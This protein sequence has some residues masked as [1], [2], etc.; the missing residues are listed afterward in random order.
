MLALKFLWDL[1]TWYWPIKIRAFLV[2]VAILRDSF[3]QANDVPC[4]PQSILNVCTT[5]LW[6]V[7]RM[8]VSC[9]TLLTGLAEVLWWRAPPSPSHLTP[10][11]TVIKQPLHTVLTIRGA[12][13]VSTCIFHLQQQKTKIVLQGTYITYIVV[14]RYMLY[15]SKWQLCKWSADYSVVRYRHVHM[16]YY[17]HS[18]EVQDCHQRLSSAFDL[19]CHLI[20][21]LTPLPNNALL[22]NLEWVLLH[23]K[24]E[25]IDLHP[26]KTTSTPGFVLVTSHMYVT[27]LT[28]F[29]RKMWM[30]VTYANS[31]IVTYPL[32]DSAIP[33][34]TE[35]YDYWHFHSVIDY[36]DQLLW[37]QLSVEST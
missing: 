27:L 9:A 30:L 25:T 19:L 12:W 28:D 15:T 18:R 20:P 16:Y 21:T 11:T 1:V 4:T 17:W 22:A 2:H 29:F 33:R 24:G 8:T 5:Y 13:D 34:A 3:V 31:T 7:K 10:F 6:A 14:M 37:D 35:S 36:L 26:V 23:A 32:L